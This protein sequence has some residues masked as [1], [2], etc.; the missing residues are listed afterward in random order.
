VLAT[1]VLRFR[2]YRLWEIAVLAALGGLAN[3]AGRSLQDW[4]LVMLALG[5]PHM[6]V[7]LAEAARSNRRR[8]LVAGLLRFDRSAK[9]AL[10][11]WALRFQLLWPALATAVLLIGSLIPPLARAMP[12]QNAADW[13]AAA[14]AHIEKLNL[15]GR[16]FTPPD[17]GS[18]L[19]WRLP[20][21][22]RTYTDTRGFF[23]PPVLIEDSHFVPQLGPD[24]RR[25]LARVLD[26]YQTEYF[27]LETTGA[28]GALWLQ[29]KDALGT[30][31]YLDDQSVLLTAAQVR[32]GIDFLAS[33]SRLK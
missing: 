24:W 5:V 33:A 16:F 26:E 30:P 2:Q 15:K 12:I 17:Y 4:L 6:T 13:P 23:Y 27:L 28:R 3:L 32:R 20:A 10:G 7:L 31:L 25:R 29:M 21:E 18:Y 22:A 1:V 14:V 19:I 8:L 11:S 9:R